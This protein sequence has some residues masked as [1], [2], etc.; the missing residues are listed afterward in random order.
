M[1]SRLRRT[2]CNELRGSPTKR[3]DNE[4]LAKETEEVGEKLRA[5]SVMKAK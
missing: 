2:S 3:G 5:C 4:E 1:T